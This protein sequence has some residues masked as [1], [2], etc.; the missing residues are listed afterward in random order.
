MTFQ[1]GDTITVT[2]G[3][4]DYDA[5]F[6]RY[7]VTPN[8]A[9]VDVTADDWTGDRRQLVDVVQI[10]GTPSA[11][12]DRG[13]LVVDVRDGNQFVIIR[14]DSSGEQAELLPG[15]ELPRHIPSRDRGEWRRV[16][17]LRRRPAAPEA[18]AEAAEALLPLVAHNHAYCDDGDATV[19]APCRSLP[20]CPTSRSL[21]EL[22]AQ[23]L[24]GDPLLEIL[25]NP[26]PARAEQAGNEAEYGLRYTLHG[27]AVESVTI[28]PGIA[29]GAHC[30]QLTR[31]IQ[32]TLGDPVDAVLIT[33]T[34]ETSTAPAGDWREVAVE[35]GM[36]YTQH[37]ATEP[38]EL[39]VPDLDAAR[40]TVN[41]M[42]QM[43]ATLGDPVDAR[44]IV[45]HAETLR[46]PAGAWRAAIDEP[47]PAT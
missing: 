1:P 26:E 19:V 21:A 43:Q 12:L 20:T 28:T 36:S 17:A 9:L 6:V 31:E 16:D 23:G 46:H 24:P 5:E 44:L 7:A 45:R 32:R 38:T 13:D 3:G 34:P 41:L 27:Q 11:P 47:L 2:R 42:R 25:G 39:P 22:R 33:R 37:G 8:T 15:D 30:R 10:S 35:Y 14:V 18:E 29:A 40:Q 4:R